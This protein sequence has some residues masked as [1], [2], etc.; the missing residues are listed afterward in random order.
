MRYLFLLL[1]AL[2]FVAVVAQTNQAQ[3]Y[4]DEGRAAY[5][6][7]EMDSAV[8][9]FSKAIEV[10]PTLDTALFNRG[11]VYLRQEKYD[12]CIEDLKTFLDRNPADAQAMV[13][14]AEAFVHK[15]DHESAIQMLH[16]AIGLNP[17]I[18][19]VFMRG[20]LYLLMDNLKGA[21]DDFNE[22]LRRSPNH[23]GALKGL[24]DH[25]FLNRDYISAQTFYFRVAQLNPND[26]QVMLDY[27]IVQAKV[28]NYMGAVGTLTDQVIRANPSIGFSAR[29][30]AHYKLGAFGEARA[31]A[32]A[33]RQANYSN[34]DAWN[35]LGL[36]EEHEGNLQ[37][38]IS[39]YSE[40]IAIDSTYAQGL[41]NLGIALYRNQEFDQAADYLLKALEYPE[42]KANAARTLASLYLTLN[43]ERQ[44]CA[45]FRL[46]AKLYY[47]PLPEEETGIFC[48]EE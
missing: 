34:P 47:D 31:D 45:Y 1:F 32:L 7:D 12:R 48:K 3:L 21:A 10:D 5:G 42:V 17:V 23:A 14:C 43:D 38:A 11:L 27:G 15:G 37:N 28:G 44:A 39:N 9:L 35:L 2:R 19:W 25:Y 6:R 36:L 16:Q 22:V 46:A 24:A 4:L 40:A 20:Q 33:A 29:G 8:K 41:C 26:P 13:L 18:D 30:F